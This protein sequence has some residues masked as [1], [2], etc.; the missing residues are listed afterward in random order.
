MLTDFAANIISALFENMTPQEKG[1][2]ANAIKKGLGMLKG[3]QG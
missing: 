1:G 2:I 3:Q